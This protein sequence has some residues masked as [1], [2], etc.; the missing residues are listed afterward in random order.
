MSSNKNIP[1]N[2]E[3]VAHQIQNGVSYHEETVRTLLSWFDHQKRGRWVVARIRNALRHL[4][5]TTVPD[6]ETAFI[7]GKVRIQK[8]AEHAR[9]LVQ[10]PMSNGSE[11]AFEEGHRDYEDPVSRVRMLPAANRPPESVLRDDPVTLAITKMLVNDFSQLPVMQGERTVHGLISWKSIGKA[12]AFGQSCEQTRDCLEK[13]A[14]IRADKPLLSAVSSI[15]ENEVVLVKENDERIIGLVTTSDVSAQFNELA[16]PFLLIAEIENHLRRI[17]DGKF[18]VDELGEACSID[19]SKHNIAGAED[20]TFGNYTRILDHPDRWER[21]GIDL[22]RKRIMDRLHEVRKIRNDVMHFSP[23]GIS[24]GDLEI[25]HDTVHFM[26][27]LSAA[28]S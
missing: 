4:D 10:T 26:Q 9:E 23:D 14:I 12:R 16:R 28:H 25:L 1:E 20:L 11:E 15:I 21:V 22:D 6:F 13:A 2:L 7:D 17:I 24:E 19:N 5:L 27:R 18:T 8:R 3:E